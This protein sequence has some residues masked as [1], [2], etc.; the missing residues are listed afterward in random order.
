MTYE[1]FKSNLIDRLQVALP[2]TVTISVQ[3]ILKNNNLILDGL[4]LTDVGINIS[5]TIY[6]DH[7]FDLYEKGTDMSDICARIVSS[8][9]NARLEESID[10][11]FFENFDRIRS[12]IIYKVINA[13][14]NET[15]LNDVPHINYMDL[16][17]VFCCFLPAN[18]CALVADSSNATI[19]IHNNHLALWGVTTDELYNVAKANTPVL[20]QPQVLPLVDTILE[21]MPDEDFGMS[22]EELYEDIPILILTNT[23]RFLGAAAILYN[24]ILG[25]CSKQLGGDFFVIPSSIHEVLLVPITPD[26]DREFLDSMVQDVNANHVAV[27]EVLSDHVYFYNHKTQALSC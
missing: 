4:L 18:S 12:H 10:M 8:Y 7:Y 9:E 5:P 26:I 25:K 23:L 3:P 6:L 22:E 17:I 27:E 16:A 14:Q 21:L 15:L 13:S 1:N 20:M 11:T 19:L 24:D 2:P